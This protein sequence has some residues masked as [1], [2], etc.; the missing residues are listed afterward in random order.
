MLDSKSAPTKRTRSE[1]QSEGSR[2]ERMPPAPKATGIRSFLN[3]NPEQQFEIVRGLASPVRVRILRLLRRRGPLN[4]NQ[5]SE[6]LGLPQSTIATNIQILEESELIDTEIGRA[7]KGQQKICAA[8]FD[9]IVIRLDDE[10]TSRQKDVIEVEMPLGLYT[11][12]NVSAP[13]GLCSTE[14]IMGVLDVPDLFLDP[15]RVQ[16]ALI[17]FGR[18]HVEYKFPNNAKVLNVTS[19]DVPGTN[20]NWPSDISLWVN[21]VKVGTWTS[22]GD[23]GDRRGIHTPRWWKLEGSQY[24]ALTQWHISSKGTFMGAK[25]LSS[26]TLAQLQLAEHH[27][28]R[29]RIGID[30]NAAHPGGVN[31]FG[32]GFGNHNHDILMRL[33]LK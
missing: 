21:D 2:T 28:I 5:I 1:R 30:D 16:A 18:G 26:V 25:K 9:E 6:A 3:V 33:H 7:R 11:S 12:Y 32:R 24:G 19:S 27:S 23:Y 31:I 13:C 29:L 4:V 14:G 15:C 22:P 17:W 20:A 8:R 10:E